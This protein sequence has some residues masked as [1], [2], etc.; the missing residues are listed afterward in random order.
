MI[1]IPPPKGFETYRPSELFRFYFQ[2]GR[3]T[4]DSFSDEFQTFTRGKLISTV[5]ISKWKNRDVIP[6][7]YSGAFL[8]M[9]ETV[10]EPRLA[11]NWTT[12][13]ETVWALHTAGHTEDLSQRSSAD[14][15]HRICVQ[16]QNWI[17]GIY[18]ERCP[19][20]V[21]APT[22][23]YVPIQVSET[24][25]TPAIPMDIEDI[26]SGKNE[27]SF[28]SGGPST[29]KSFAALHL[30]QSLCAGDIFPIY[31][32]G[33][34][35][36][37]IDLD[38]I[39]P[40]KSIGDS[41]SIRSFL[42]HFRGSRFTKACLILDGL[43]E[44]SPHTHPDVN[45]V[46]SLIKQFKNEQA[47]C[48]AHNKNLQIIAFSSPVHVA[49]SIDRSPPN[50]VTHYGL[51]ALDGSDR[52]AENTTGAIQGQDLR[53]MYWDKYLNAH[54]HRPDPS[55]PD[56]L[57]VEYD[58]F[59][60]FGRDPLLT[61]LICQTSLETEHYSATGK[62]PHERVNALTQTS[63]KNEIY[64]AIIDYQAQKLGPLLE[65]EQA[66]I[67]LQH[68][69]IVRWQNE[70]ENSISLQSFDQRIPN[71]KIDAAF[72][73]LGLFAPAFQTP[74]DLIITSFQF[75]HLKEEKEVRFGVI[76]FAHET[77]AEYLVAT[78]LFDS[79]I[80]LISAYGKK[81]EFEEALCDWIR[82]S[83]KG[84]HKPSLAD[85]CQN[86]AA[87][88]YNEISDLNWDTA[89]KICCDDIF[90]ADFQTQGANAF[91]QMQNSS[92]LLFFIWSCLNLEHQKR[93]GT[94]FLLSNDSSQF[95]ASNLKTIQRPNGLKFTSESV[96]EPRLRDSTFVTPSLSA[97]HLKS[98]DMSQLSLSL[99][100]IENLTCEDTSF[101]MSHWSHVKVTAGQFTGTMFQQA[102][103]HQWRILGTRLSHCLFQGCRFQGAIFSDC[104]IKETFFTQ[105][106][107]TNVE[108]IAADFEN[109]VF[110]RC[111]FSNCAFSP[112]RDLSVSM[113]A[114]FYHCTFMNMDR[115]LKDI[116][117]R[118][119]IDSISAVK[120]MKFP[121]NGEIEYDD[122]CE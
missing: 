49:I 107:L 103:F 93:T 55:L 118:N 104:G 117:S 96:N 108:F 81:N 111:I 91:S 78:L 63:N 57:S 73:A 85:F 38:I 29:G 58:D 35:L 109:V 72:Q 51:R 6:T 48:A 33:C 82:V 47:A 87:I 113:D 9:I 119:V 42:K 37:D 52:A 94:A 4:E 25:T 17:E 8:K 71:P 53:A 92:S 83:S 24:E 36:S 40:Q 86:E 115:A 18:H 90:T 28:I 120:S 20:Q 45:A 50:K 2:A 59:F 13:F 76:E 102:L 95:N 110:D 98:A 32:R 12:A 70:N 121:S 34:N 66:L 46:A 106:H 79:F 97:L 67:V 15:S 27:W 30:A 84:A 116:P 62:L 80:D 44:V 122:R 5:T 43:N 65:A 112:N 75:R 101:A 100:H 22:D 99:G 77:F 74:P 68:L 69:A 21:F 61:F 105:C 114:K 31:I 64:R 56:F 26:V 14:I 10:V 23:I 19:G 1:N 88:R 60:E 41:F 16:H 89:L 7:R 54:G 11:K 39:D 3:W